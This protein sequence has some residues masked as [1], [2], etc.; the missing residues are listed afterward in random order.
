MTREAA[1]SRVC[2]GASAGIPS[3]GS[4]QIHPAPWLPASPGSHPADRCSPSATPGDPAACSVSSDGATCATST[5]CTPPSLPRSYF[6]V[7]SF[8]IEVFAA[9]E[10]GA[11]TGR[12]PGED[13][14]GR[15]A[16]EDGPGP[17][18]GGGGAGRGRGGAD[19]GENLG[20]RAVCVIHRTPRAL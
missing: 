17:G 10:D 18:A 16:G 13:G 5:S 7:K 12:G 1:S 11:G 2:S 19:R 9:R 6:H 8:E 3:A 14:A 4:P 20:G 15:G